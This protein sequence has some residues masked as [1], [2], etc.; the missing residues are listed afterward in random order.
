MSEWRYIN[1]ATK[2]DKDLEGCL[3]DH[4]FKILGMIVAYLKEKEGD[5]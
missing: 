1:T 5:Q 3:T 2:S 4:I